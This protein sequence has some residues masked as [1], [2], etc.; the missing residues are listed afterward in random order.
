MN[1]AL[2][3][4]LGL[5]CAAGLPPVAGDPPAPETSAAAPT[6]V[7]APP[8]APA[9]T[10]P[11]GADLVSTTVRGALSRESS[12]AWTFTPCSGAATLLGG[13]PAPALTSLGAG[14]WQVVLAVLPGTSPTLVEVDY[15]SPVGDVCNTALPLARGTE[16]GWALHWTG[17]VGTFETGAQPPEKVT[18]WTLGPGPCHDGAAGA[19]YHRTASVTVRRITYQVC[20][21]EAFPSEGR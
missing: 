13:D 8:S 5:A 17:A 4:L 14:P 21:I 20:A 16:P 12:G 3:P 2:L 6:P 10:A 1:T 7:L 18:S 19:Y 9:P 15:A 11:P